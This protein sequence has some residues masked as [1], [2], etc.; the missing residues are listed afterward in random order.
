MS[1]SEKER[2]EYFRITDRVVI[3][4]TKLTNSQKLD[5]I[6]DENSSFLLG[7]A[8]NA[9]DNESQTLA[10]IIKRSNPDIAHYFDIINKK[11][12]LISNYILDSSPENSNQTET[13]IDLSGSGIAIQSNDD[14]SVDDLL[15]IKLLLLPEKKGIICVGCIKR[16]KIENNSKTLCI[17]FEDIAESDR[18]LIVKHTISKQLEEA[19]LK[20]NYD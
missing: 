12:D 19:R 1:N 2:R 18:E 5:D 15:M 20:N 8:I 16:I 9:L 10:N 17:D 4:V 3:S 13:E 11:I 14:F 6:K 7:S